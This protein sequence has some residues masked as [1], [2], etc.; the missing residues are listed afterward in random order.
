MA[1]APVITPSVD[2]APC[3]RAEV[4]FS[5]FA[6]GTTFV[7]AYRLGGGRE[8]RMRGAVNTPVAG[9]LTRIDFEV[10]FGLEVSYRAEMFNSAGSS[11]GYTDATS[12][13]LNVNETWL[14][15][16]LDP[17]G[18]V[19]VRMASDAARSISRPVPGSVLYPRGRR[20][21]IVVSEPRQGIQG[22][23]L[24]CY[25]LTDDDTD[26]FADMVGT[27]TSNSVPV[28][29]VRVGADM[30]MRVPRPLFASVLDPREEAIN[31]HIGGESMKWSMSGD[32]VSPPTPALFIPLLTRADINAYYSTRSAVKADNLTRL[33]VNRRYDLAGTA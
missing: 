29:C 26:R 3:P 9:A 6:A 1:Y 5:S 31:L 23:A 16:P 24:D 7:T 10:P 22:I 28:L 21:G 8:Y 20:V 19:R 27:Y 11:L 30:K 17:Q 33:A 2:A 12:V 4:L 14:H 13:T 18:A 32:E 15:N 25:T